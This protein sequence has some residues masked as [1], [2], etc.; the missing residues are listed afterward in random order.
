MVSKARAHCLRTISPQKHTLNLM[1]LRHQPKSRSTTCINECGSSVSAAPSDHSSRNEPRHYRMSR[2][3]AQTSESNRHPRGRW[4][5]SRSPCPH[6]SRCAERHSRQKS[7]SRTPS[8]QRSRKNDCAITISN[9]C[10]PQQSTLKGKLSK[11][12]NPVSSQAVPVLKS[13]LKNSSGLTAA[14]KQLSSSNNDM[15]QF[16]DEIKLNSIAVA[17][18]RILDY[19]SH[20]NS[21][22]SVRTT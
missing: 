18:K 15:H 8:S 4:N 1:D 2:S 7:R 22:G 12:I 9:S 3:N 6:R 10:W 14:M 21:S 20:L 19:S 5:S 11:S 13:I 17:S 16:Y